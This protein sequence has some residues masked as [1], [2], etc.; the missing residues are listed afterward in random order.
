MQGFTELIREY[1]AP[2]G[3]LGFYGA[4]TEFVIL[5]DIR[6]TIFGA[7]YDRRDLDRE[8][9]T[10]ELYMSVAGA[11]VFGEPIEI[12]LGRE[13]MQQATFELDGSGEAPRYLQISLKMERH[14]TATTYSPRWYQS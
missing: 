13:Q 10:A 8:L 1:H 6:G 11:R 9:A 3:T 14:S 4:E 2:E 7:R 12:F 5:L